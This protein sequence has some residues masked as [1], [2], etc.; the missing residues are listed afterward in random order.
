MYLTLI[1]DDAV[2]LAFAFSRIERVH[3]AIY[4]HRVAKRNGCNSGWAKS[5]PFAGA[6][7]GLLIINGGALAIV[8][9]GLKVLLGALRQFNFEGCR[10]HDTM[11]DAVRRRRPLVSRLIGRVERLTNSN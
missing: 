7:S 3:E 10:V 8:L 4:R 5:S 1:L 9:A 2:K 11:R 6:N